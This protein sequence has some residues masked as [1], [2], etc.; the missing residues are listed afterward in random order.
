M[1]NEED[2]VEKIFK[3]VKD[4]LKD[5]KKIS[6]KQEE[7]LNDIRK[8]LGKEEKGLRRSDRQGTKSQKEQTK[9]LE[10]I[11]EKQNKTNSCLLYTSPS[12]RDVEE[13]RMPSSA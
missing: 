8:M 9:R 3:D 12:P 7:H 11:I 1:V 5:N 4:I 10:Y 6:Q 2:R 13:S